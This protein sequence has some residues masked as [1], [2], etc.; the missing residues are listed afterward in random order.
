[1][2]S[3]VSAN[4][5]RVFALTDQV[6]KQGK[7]ACDISFVQVIG[8]GAMGADIATYLCLKGCDVVLSDINADALARATDKAFAYFDRKLSETAASDAKK[9]D[10]KAKTLATDIAETIAPETTV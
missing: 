8:A 9:I 4:L 3:D 1:M 6:K 2:M 7:G 10:L 5:R